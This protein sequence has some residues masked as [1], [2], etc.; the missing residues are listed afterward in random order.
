LA[1]R[2]N[3]LT[4]P[5]EGEAGEVVRNHEVGSASDAWGHPPSR[6]PLGDVDGRA[7]TMNE[8]QERMARYHEPAHTRALRG[9]AKF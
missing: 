4:S 9:S 7:R 6:T 8:S 2:C 5:A 3:K 1:V